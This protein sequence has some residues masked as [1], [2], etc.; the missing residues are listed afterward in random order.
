[1]ITADTVLRRKPDLV[2]SDMGGETVMLD[3]DSGRYFGLSGVG[4]HLWD[5]LARDTRV[6]ALVASVREQF[7]AAPDE[8]VEHDVM[9]FL[10][11]LVDKGLV[12]VVG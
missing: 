6:D 2:A 7:D 1:M 11:R 4:P 9:E 3:I 8:D 10:N 5:A 12:R